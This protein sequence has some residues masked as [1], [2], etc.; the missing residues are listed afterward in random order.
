MMFQW[1]LM[2]PFIYNYHYSLIPHEVMRRS[3]LAREYPALY[4]RLVGSIVTHRL[5]W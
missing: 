5:G 2:K 1:C 4:C 3:N